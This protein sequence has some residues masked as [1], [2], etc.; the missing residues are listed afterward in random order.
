MV[1]TLHLGGYYFLTS[2]LLFLKTI[3]NFFISKKLNRYSLDTLS[4][5]V[6]AFDTINERV[7]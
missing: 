7:N 2:A 4:N 1:K 6:V 5:F 3:T